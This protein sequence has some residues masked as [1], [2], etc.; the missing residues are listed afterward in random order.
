MQNYSGTLYFD[1][2]LTKFF[3]EKDRIETLTENHDIKISVMGPNKEFLAIKV[4]AP[5]E[6]DNLSFIFPSNDP[7]IFVCYREKLDNALHSVLFDTVSKVVDIFEDPTR[8]FQAYFTRLGL[9]SIQ[10][11][12][13]KEFYTFE[14]D[15][16]QDYISERTSNQESALLCESL[17]DDE[18]QLLVMKTKAGDEDA[19]LRLAKTAEQ[20]NAKAQTLLGTLYLNGEGIKQ[21]KAEAINWFRRAVELGDAVAQYSLGGCYINGDGV[22]RDFNE[23]MKLF[24]LSALQGFAPAQCNIANFYNECQNYTEAIRWL[25]KAA[26]QGN[27]QA[28]YN[29]GFYYYQG[30][31]ISQ[32]KGKAFECFR[33]AAENEHPL[34]FF[35]LGLCYYQGEGTIQ[36]KVEAKKWFEKAAALGQENAIMILSAFY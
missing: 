21:D 18:L 3:S 5:G 32:D 11:M 29:L 22:G 27:A 33:K 31:G 28:L 20:G 34:A 12:T 25:S 15:S 7:A 1:A 8:I 35:N 36:N 4:T 2:R 24:H 13:K 19:H 16:P 17:T 14:S 10:E 6:M 26:L 30:K 9:F 23:A